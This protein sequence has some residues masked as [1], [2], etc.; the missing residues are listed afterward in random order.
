MQAAQAGVQSESAGVADAQPMDIEAAGPSEVSPDNAEGQAG[1]SSL[2]PQPSCSHHQVHP[3][4]PCGRCLSRLELQMVGCGILPQLYCLLRSSWNMSLSSVQTRHPRMPAAH[5][6]R[7]Q[8]AYLRKILAGSA[9]L[10]AF[11]C[12]LLRP[13]QLGVIAASIH[14]VLD[15][16]ECP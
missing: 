11:L 13:I 12:C 5:W 15:G 10:K 9:E 1:P 4:H 2:D 16:Q 3:L 8:H 6:S 7:H 14:R